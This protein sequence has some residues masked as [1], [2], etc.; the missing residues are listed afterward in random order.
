M[1][2]TPRVA[3][4]VT[5]VTLFAATHV[6]LAASPY[7]IVLVHG[8][9]SSHNMWEDEGLLDHFEDLGWSTAGVYHFTLRQQ[10]KLSDVAIDWASMPPG[11]SGDVWRVNFESDADPQSN[12]A[13]IYLQAKAIGLAIDDIKANTGA[14]KVILLGH[15]MGGLAAMAYV[16]GDPDGNVAKVVTLGTPFGGSELAFFS[17]FTCHSLTT[18]AERD[19]LKGLPGHVNVFLNGGNE[20]EVASGFWNDVNCNG[21]PGDQ[22]IG[23]RE[24]TWD[25]DWP[26]DIS[27]FFIVGRGAADSDCVVSTKDQYLPFG[28]IKKIGA[29]HTSKCPEL[30]TEAA[31]RDAI[32]EALDESGDPTN[33][34]PL[35]PG[36]DTIGFI[37]SHDVADLDYDYFQVNTHGFQ[38][39]NVSLDYNHPDL[40]LN[41]AQ[42]T[43]YSDTGEILDSSTCEKGNISRNVRT[44]GSDHVLIEVKG[45]AEPSSPGLIFAPIPGSEVFLHSLAC[46]QSVTNCDNCR[47]PYH[48]R[49]D[50]D[51]PIPTG[52]FVLKERPVEPPNGTP[53]TT[54]LFRADYYDPDG[55]EP[56]A[57]QLQLDEELWELSLESGTASNGVYSIA[58][59]GLAEGHHQ[60]RFNSENEPDGFLATPP[61]FKPFV[62]DGSIDPS[63]RD[64]GV[65]NLESNVSNLP[66]G[67]S[68]TLTATFHNWGL[69]TEDVVVD[70]YLYDP[71]GLEVGHETSSLE[72][73]PAGVDSDTQTKILSTNSTEGYWTAVVTAR[74]A[75][76]AQDDDD[77]ENDLRALPFHVGIAT[78][79]SQYKLM[80]GST[81]TTG[82]TVWESVTGTEEYG[83]TAVQPGSSG[84]LVNIEKLSIGTIDTRTLEDDG[85]YRFDGGRY[86]I[87]VV[88]LDSGN[89][90]VL[91]GQPNP[92][93]FVYNPAKP[94]GAAGATLYWSASSPS[95]TVD[96]AVPSDIIHNLDV[97]AWYSDYERVGDEMVREFRV[98]P[99]ASPGTYSFY[100]RDQLIGDDTY[101]YLKETEMII[102][103]GH[104][105]SVTNLQPSEGTSHVAGDAI[106]VS[107]LLSVAGGYSET[108]TVLLTITGPDDYVYLDSQTLPLTGSQTVPFETPWQT[109]G[110]PAGDYTLTV[111]ASVAGDVDPTND[112]QTATIQLTEPPV[113]PAPPT[114][115]ECLPI[116]ATSIDLTWIDN[117]TTEIGFSI[118]SSTDALSWIEVGTASAEATSYRMTALDPDTLYYYRLRSFTAEVASSPSNPLSARTHEAKSLKMI[119]PDGGE[120][121]ERGRAAT[122][123]WDSTGLIDTVDLTLLQGGLPPVTIA[124]AVPDTGVF[125]WWIPDDQQTAADFRISV[126]SSLDPAVA[127]TSDDD[128]EIVEKTYRLDL[129]SEPGGIADPRSGIYT[130]DRGTIVQL[131]ALP[132]EGNSFSGWIGDVE[133]G[134]ELDNPLFLN[135]DSDKTLNARF[136]GENAPEIHLLQSGL[137]LP[138]NSTVDFGQVA[139]GSSAVVDVV[140]ENR[141]T[142]KLKLTVPLTILGA[143]TDRFLVTV[144]P[145]DTV[146]PGLS[147]SFRV[148]FTPSSTGTRGAVAWIGSNDYDEH[149]YP[150]NLQ[151]E[152]FI[153]E[154][155][156]LEVTITPQDAVDAG[157]QWRVAGGAWLDSGQLQTAL[158]VGSYSVEFKDLSGWATPASQTLVVF[159]DQTTTTVGT[160]TKLTGSLQ[161]TLTPQEAIDLGGQ[162]QVDGGA[163]HDSGYTEAGLIIGPHTI[164]FKTVSGWNAPASQSVLI[165]LGHT[166]SLNGAY[167]FATG[168]AQVVISPQEAIDLGAQW[169][170]D[171]G[172]WHDSGLLV[173]GLPVGL[174]SV[175]FKTITGWSSP[176]DQNVTIYSGQ[177]TA[178]S[179]LYS[180]SPLP[181]FFLNTELTTRLVPSTLSWAP[182]G[183]H[184]FAGM[185]SADEIYGW[186]TEGWTE[187]FYRTDLHHDPLSSAVDANGQKVAFGE[188]AGGIEIYDAT[189][190]YLGGPWD[191]SGDVLG[192]AWI[193]DKMVALINGSS[194]PGDAVTASGIYEVTPSGQY[195]LKATL[196]SNYLG[197]G[198]EIIYH[199]QKNIF[200]YTTDIDAGTYDTTAL[201]VHRGDYPDQV[202]VEEFIDE[203]GASFLAFSPDGETLAVVGGIT[204]VILCDTSSGNCGYAFNDG[205]EYESV[206]FLEDDLI[207][208][209]DLSSTLV[210]IFDLSGDLKDQIDTG[211]AVRSL[212]WNESKNLLAAALLNRKTQI[213]EWDQGSPIIEAVEVSPSY[214]YY[215]G[216]QFEVACRLVDLSSGIA[217]TSA[218]ARIRTSSGV[219]VDE[220][221]MVQVAGSSY[222]GVWDSS[223]VQAGL[224]L[225]GVYVEDRVGHFAELESAWELNLSTSVITGTV[226]DNTGQGVKEVKVEVFD[227]DFLWLATTTTDPD[228]NYSISGLEPGLYRLRFS[229]AVLS[230]YYSMQW[231][232]GAFNFEQATP[233]LLVEDSASTGIDVQLLAGGFVSGRVTA[234]DS[235]NGL[236]GVLIEIFNPDAGYV[237]T[238]SSVEDGYYY[239]SGLLPGSYKIRF[240]PTPLTGY[241]AAEWYDDQPH[242]DSAQTVTVSPGLILYGYDSQLAS[243][244]FISGQVL[245]D[246]GQGVA[247]VHVHVQDQDNN[248]LTWSITDGAGSYTTQFGIPSGEYRVE[249]N[250]SWLPDSWLITEWYENQPSFDS[251]DPVPV[252][253]GTTT[254]GIGAQLEAGG[255]ISGMVTDADTST[256]LEDVEIKVFG[257]DGSYLMSLWSDATG[258]YETPSAIASGSYYILTHNNLGYFDE[259]YDGVA[260]PNSDC[261][262]ADGKAISVV[263]QFTATANITLRRGGAISGRITDVTNGQPLAD[264]WVNVFD[265]DGWWKTNASAGEDGYYRTPGL[266]TGTYYLH[267][268]NSSRYF[269]VIYDDFSCSG[270]CDPLSGTPVSV[271][272]GTTTE[273][274]DFALT[275]GGGQ[276]KGTLTE[277]STGAPLPWECVEIFDDRG[278]WMT[279]GC[280]DST[281]I[282]ASFGGLTSGTY[283]VGTN[284][285]RGFIDEVY[286]DIPCG[287]Y[288][289]DPAI[290]TPVPVTQGA[291]TSGIDIALAH[292]GL[293]S[294]R[295][296]ESDTQTPLPGIQ[297]WIYNESGLSVTS[298]WTDESGLYTTTASLPDGTY[299]AATWNDLGYIDEL[300]DD[301]P[302]NGCDVTAGTALTILGGGDVMGIDFALSLG[303]TIEG[304]V[305]D[306]TTS[307]GIEDAWVDIYNTVGDYLLSRE[308]DA[309]GS[310]RVD[311]LS[312]G[313]YYAVSGNADGY[314]N[315]L[316]EGVRCPNGS[317]D[318]TTG[319]QIVVSPGVVTSGVNF[320]LEKGGAISGDITDISTGLG[321]SAAWVDIFDVQGNFIGG[322]VFDGNGSYSTAGLEAGTYYVRSR[323]MS[324]YFDQVYDGIRCVGWCN[325][326]LGTPIPVAIG[327][328]TMDIDFALEK[329]SLIAGTIRDESV[330][331]GIERAW[332]DIFDSNGV[333]VTTSSWTDSSGEYISPGVEPGTHY[334]RVSNASGYLD[335]LYDDI[336]C[337]GS[338]DISAGTPISVAANSTVDGIDFELNKGGTISGRVTDSASGL[339]ILQ[340]R[341]DIYDSNGSFF[342]SV[343]TDPSGGYTTTG[344]PGGTYYV[345][346]F[347]RLGFLDELYDD[348]LCE[349]GCDITGGHPVTVVVG[350]TTGGVD[351]ALVRG[352]AI[353]GSITDSSTGE[354]IA[355]VGV[356]IYDGEGSWV[357][358]VSSGLDGTYTSDRAL[359]TGT[360]HAVTYNLQGYVDELF[361]DIACPG[362]SCDVTTGTSI[363]VTA[364]STTSGVDFA[365]ALGGAISGE[366]TDVLT[367]SPI[368]DVVIQI[369]D[370]NGFFVTSCRTDGIGSYTSESILPTGAYFAAT[371]NTLGYADELYDNLPCVGGCDPTSGTGITVTG[372]ATRSGVDFALLDPTIDTTP[373]T[374][375]RV[376]TVSA[377]PDKELVAGEKVSASITQIYVSFSEPVS[378][379][380]GDSGSHDVTN[381]DNFL[382]VSDGSNG[383]FDTVSC[384]TQPHP[385]DE[386][387]TVDHVL[388]DAATK[389]AM[390][391][392]EGEAAL[393]EDIYR[394][395]VCGSTSIVD[396]AGNALDGDGDGIGGDD[397]VTEFGV[398]ATNS[399]L[400]PNFDSDLHS[401]TLISPPGDEIA[402]A[403]TD[404]DDAPTSGSAR[405]ENLSGLDEP[406]SLS[407]CFDLT[408]NPSLTAGGLV[409]I[410]GDSGVDPVVDLSFEFYSQPGCAGTFLRNEIVASLAGNTAGSWS[411]RLFGSA[412]PPSE[413]ISVLVR[414]S[415]EFGL[416][417]TTEVYFD[418]L[419]ATGDLLIF[420]DGFES[421]STSSWSNVIGD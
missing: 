213:Y 360:Y 145:S 263:P 121:L 22:V 23:L 92:V 366:V 52:P 345:S 369:Y 128:F 135:M 313:T 241:Y 4:A 315:E 82:V 418:S 269:D 187:V 158:P 127:D 126:T 125:E 119:A 285:T 31:S 219:L 175:G 353:S 244:G 209:G 143:D 258:G 379:P 235:A 42:V 312:P 348:M 330:G 405:L 344:I 185:D 229:P 288:A 20:N 321:I 352:G 161:V 197:K 103:P 56:T 245:D 46:Y 228:G 361:D 230:G 144:Q 233:V 179:G 248:N 130:H 392:L 290:G 204:G 324:G 281:G 10:D 55:D 8:L 295:V 318:P 6:L 237:D 398:I 252:V 253:A 382:L 86:L 83:F 65:S 109:G 200:A 274:I 326:T 284:N 278:N 272:E 254:T 183:S 319:T 64:V 298:A 136:D 211:Y 129:S 415:V 226:T 85:I 105:V 61:V 167:T 13:A 365:L 358:Y 57:V 294:G 401:W 381:P 30:C 147:T 60:Y 153:Q 93:P 73:L 351:F 99:T 242:F 173:T 224:Y 106:D 292:G 69:S 276:I 221:P 327:A 323:N 191:E 16:A 305:T 377:T 413:A 404:A 202:L 214:G 163:W 410:G 117:S 210:K 45:Y 193:G 62:S 174:H 118:E 113:P 234:A 307:A 375:I 112:T 370:A 34:W 171:G 11:G 225:V 373:P 35:R 334:A 286:D 310:Y 387:V 406:Y 331:S 47:A 329:G 190:Q 346:T 94:R 385:L 374:V 390:V 29:V 304:T 299:T 223:G 53:A 189:G 207:A 270:G 268:S 266:P 227:S 419:F 33:P 157:A 195:I 188:N 114:L 134:H 363:D 70:W 89:L 212:A 49:V 267:C 239:T 411:K 336:P 27:Y 216:T 416:A 371:S 59:T 355:G 170:V 14:E 123:T 420:A 168:S 322:A 90:W 152:G 151:G 5:F 325:V 110:M 186:E 277:A 198:S 402:R 172:I 282:Y 1:R 259:L 54:F 208:V 342:T 28:E 206:A 271:V 142:A 150:L 291:I 104:D 81:T 393:P 302:C 26:H 12:C 32:I 408:P 409:K 421:G 194:D 164:A 378:D 107:C 232:S 71:N 383:I 84:W 309:A 21:S 111:T 182:D 403:S 257:F 51:A 97:R 338:C 238:S 37:T 399:L 359:A 384:A 50:T 356:H 7:P 36:V 160:Y 67:S 201:Y 177:T 249:L 256:P 367:S 339:G 372:G 316:Y 301:A 48:I 362:D 120:S 87:H 354:G 368:S 287:G 273:P 400:N 394:L 395:F 217:E 246:Q 250:T 275:P 280:T 308:V 72:A 333:L 17:V 124:T 341:V 181:R 255:R 289:C 58:L 44:N 205:V 66:P 159:G 166:S 137:D 79:Y 328:T 332:V 215:V 131:T 95:G 122:L 293:V 317:C 203:E 115:T 391:G 337:V 63:G 9:N 247:N 192:I 389:T 108:G 24:L 296:T 414:F 140:L 76:R 148:V 396:A 380:A 25:S 116:S 279:S 149:P 100:I 417:E 264:A 412:E 75:T 306:E 169:Q 68:I 231:Y 335:E 222:A 262:L 77:L 162:W 146:D 165:Y 101:H 74:L 386:P 96:N 350:E 132:Y 138:Y 311:R 243:G 340:V 98:P 251:A 297:V 300:Y 240:S 303:G 19:L 154:F 80:Y 265:A 236:G 196:G 343:Y 78:D 347:N 261:D 139:P 397:F 141:G 349:M 357:D 133:P 364:G 220:I 155:G 39:L 15:S 178:L 283:F 176:A 38:S 41:C 102:D 18:A 180:T 376:K 388:Y 314:F 88:I 184:L 218:I 91:H 2:K 407:Q 3:A 260:C 320:V 43:L 156:S 40:D 199:A